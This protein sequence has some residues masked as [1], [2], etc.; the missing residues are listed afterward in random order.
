MNLRKAA[1]CAA[2][3]VSFVGATFFAAPR[4]LAI[5]TLGSNVDSVMSLIYD[6]SNGNV[7]VEN[8]GQFGAS[9]QRLTLASSTPILIPANLNIAPLIPPAPAPTIFS[10]TASLLDIGRPVGL[11]GTGSSLGAILPP[12]VPTA[13]LLSELTITYQGT[14]SPGPGSIGDLLISVVGGS[15]NN[16]VLPGPGNPPGF[17]RFFN[18]ATGQWFDPP[19]TFGYDYQMNSASQ[20]TSV[21]LP[22][23]LGNNY[24]VTSNEGIVTGLQGGAVHA[25]SSGVTG[26]QITGI[27]PLVDGDQQDAFPV[28]LTFDTPT[29]SFSMQALNVPE[30]C[31][32]A[33]AGLALVGV[34]R[35]RRA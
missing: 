13:T 16:P 6:P 20:F 34:A 22:V 21:G 24:T 33:M 27:S 19:M 29:A 28:F 9:V 15:Q 31:A 30:P 25:F 35:R 12:G 5:T 2:A 4:A 18:V 10:N 1:L 32:T 11:L 23:G 7:F 14:V 8:F 3:L 26:F 17:F